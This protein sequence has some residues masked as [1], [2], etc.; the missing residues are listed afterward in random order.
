[1][2]SALSQWIVCFYLKIHTVKLGA[3][4]TYT[5]LDDEISC[6]APLACNRPEQVRRILSIQFTRPMTTIAFPTF[7]QTIACRSTA[8][9]TKVRLPLSPIQLAITEIMRYIF[10]APLESRGDQ[11]VPLHIFVS[12]IQADYLASD[13][14]C[15]PMTKPGA[16]AR[17]AKVGGA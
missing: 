2:V 14:I 13:F 6:E 3:Q 5:T 9:K 4:S 16:S 11:E 7:F 8:L 15:A 17:S 10:N 12:R 1:V